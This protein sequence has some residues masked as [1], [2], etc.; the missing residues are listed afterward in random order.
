M[1]DLVQKDKT[2]HEQ[3]RLDALVKQYGK[4]GF[5]AANVGEFK[6]TKASKE[7]GPDLAHLRS[8]GFPEKLDQAD[9][10]LKK[11]LRPKEQGGMTKEQANDWVNRHC[12]FAAIEDLRGIVRAASKTELTD[13]QCDFHVVR[14]ACMAMA[15]QASMDLAGIAKQVGVDLNKL[16]AD[17]VQQ[18]KKDYP[19][20]T[21]AVFDRLNSAADVARKNRPDAFIPNVQPVPMSDNYRTVCQLVKQYA[22]DNPHL[23]FD[24]SKGVPQQ[25]QQPAR[26]SQP[27]LPTSGPRLRTPPRPENQPIP[28]QPVKNPLP[29]TRRP[30]PQRSPVPA[31]ASQNVKVKVAG[32]LREA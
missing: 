19:K 28:R 7:Q 3:E 9:R 2:P 21:Q 13:E 8:M 6:M 11:G 16:V 27:P 23:S 5:M 20:A 29:Q 32:N 24:P 18:H 17:A 14:I 26:L 31:M 12:R 30:L 22:A 15:K 1:Y 4:P 25:Q 10:Y